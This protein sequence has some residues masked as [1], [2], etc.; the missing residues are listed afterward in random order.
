MPMDAMQVTKTFTFH[1]AHKDDDATDQCGG[2]HG[3]T[4]KLELTAEGHTKRRMLIHA[5]LIK[6]IYRDVLEPKLE[7]KYLNETLPINPTMENTTRWIAHTF[8]TELR[9]HKPEGSWLMSVCVRL[10]ETPTM[11]CTQKESL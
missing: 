9:E 8:A 3:H 2:L 11:Y 5:D 6:Q 10:W 1:A 4:F 7:H